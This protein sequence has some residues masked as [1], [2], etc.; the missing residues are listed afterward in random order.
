[1]PRLS[2]EHPDH[3]IE[4]DAEVIECGRGAARDLVHLLRRGEVQME[5]DVLRATHFVPK[6]AFL[7]A[8]DWPY[9]DESFRTCARFAE[10]LVLE[11]GAE[12]ANEYAQAVHALTHLGKPTDIAEFIKGYSKELRVESGSK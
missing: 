11:R 2:R 6:W 4:I 8:I 10:R 12:A 3:Y 1:M 9:G 5:F 7:L